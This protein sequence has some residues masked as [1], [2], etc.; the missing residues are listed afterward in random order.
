MTTIA[1]AARVPLAHR[2]AL[3]FP[4]PP[5]LRRPWAALAVRLR[6]LVEPPRM[7]LRID[8]NHP[9]ERIE[10]ELEALYLRLNTPGDAINACT[11]LPAL[12][13]GLVFHHREADGKHYLYV[14][15]PRAVA[16][17]V[18]PCSTA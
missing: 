17:P 18:T 6:R 14:E 2:S 1:L 8:V 15:A 10:A 5:P 16:S 11:R 7:E 4:Q 13:P 9:D 3:A 12:R